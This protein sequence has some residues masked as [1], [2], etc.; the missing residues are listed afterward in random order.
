MATASVRPWRIPQGQSRACSQERMAAQ[1]GKQ[2]VVVREA[3][4]IAYLQ[5]EIT[6]TDPDRGPIS[7]REAAELHGPLWVLTGDNPYSVRLTDKQNCHR[8]RELVRRLDEEGQPYLVSA[9]SS[10]RGDWIERSVALPRTG[11]RR[12]LALGREMDQN[13]VFKITGAAQVVVGCRGRWQRS[14]PHTT[15]WQP[16]SY[17]DRTLDE[18]LHHELGFELDPT[19]WRFG[20]QVGAWMGPRACHVIDAAPTW[21]WLPLCCAPRRGTGTRPRR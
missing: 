11:R 18:V 9:G 21:K 3:R 4:R 1:G 10:P 14:R 8:H 19:F 2:P 6:V 16:A 12:A 5:T 17:S 13:A 7:A 15:A 20:S